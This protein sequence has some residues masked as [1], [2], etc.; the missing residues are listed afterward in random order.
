MNG[1]IQF[2][3]KLAA[4]PVI[5]ERKVDLL[6]A[7]R[8]TGSIT[9]AAK[10]AGMS[11]RRAWL[12]LDELNRIFR[13]PVVDSSFGGTSG[14]GTRLTALGMVVL[15][16]CDRV[17]RKVDEA[18]RDEVQALTQLISVHPKPSTDKNARNF[19]AT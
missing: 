18:V 11:Y 13:D 12:H 4:F 3:V 16:L 14:G 19:T 6:R 8:E 9:A 15:S 17:Q 10:A 5:G 7:V 1:S 2:G